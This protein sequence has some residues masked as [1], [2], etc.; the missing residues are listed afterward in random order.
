MSQ[1]EQFESWCCERWAGDRGA[2]LIDRSGEYKSGHVEF[3]WCAYQAGH[4]DEIERLRAELAHAERV[5]AAAGLMEASERC[6]MV[7]REPALHAALDALRGK[8]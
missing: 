5:L 4:E 7:L 8:E 2:L 1:R 6:H 3:A